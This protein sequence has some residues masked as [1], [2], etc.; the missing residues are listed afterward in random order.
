[1]LLSL[2]LNKGEFDLAVSF[3]YFICNPQS[4]P[5]KNKELNLE[6]HK[7][8]HYKADAI[9]LNTILKGIGHNFVSNTCNKDLID[10]QNKILKTAA[11]HH[12]SHDRISFNTL[13]NNYV[14]A[15]SISDAFYC[16]DQMK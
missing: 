2:A 6:Y 8:Q 7:K 13:I 4:S 9:S 15:R 10:L 5:N 1:M 14:K 11:H 12:I 16:F 3:F